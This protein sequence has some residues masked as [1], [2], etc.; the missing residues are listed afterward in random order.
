M[1]NITLIRPLNNP[2]TE[3]YPKPRR[4][5][6]DHHLAPLIRLGKASGDL[7]LDVEVHHVSPVLR[8]SKRD[9]DVV[10]VAILIPIYRHTGATLVTS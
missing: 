1:H 8:P 7:P 6:L 5:M 3:L 4:P 10:A 9:E 2:R